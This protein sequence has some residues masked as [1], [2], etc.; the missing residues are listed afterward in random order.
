[1]TV[2]AVAPPPEGLCLEG[3]RDAGMRESI[4]WWMRSG[5]FGE[6]Q[7]SVGGEI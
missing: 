2:V 7:W 6:E 5:M 1:M 4:D 3:G